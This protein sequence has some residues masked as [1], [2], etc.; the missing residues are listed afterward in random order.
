MSDAPPA[1][2]KQWWKKSDDGMKE[3]RTVTRDLLLTLRKNQVDEAK[4]PDAGLDQVVREQKE[5]KER[6]Y[7]QA[8]KHMD[9]IS[10]AYDCVS[11]VEKALTNTSDSIVQLTHELYKGQANIQINDTR[12]ELREKRPTSENFKDS[13]SD[14]LSSEHKILSSNRD[15]LRALKQDGKDI[16]AKLQDQRVKLSSHTGERRVGMLRDIGSLNEKVTMVPEGDGNNSPKKHPGPDIKD[17]KSLDTEGDGVIKECL[18]LLDRFNKHR[19]KTLDTCERCQAKREEA[20]FRTEETLVK[21]VEQM[22]NRREDLEKQL[23]DVKAAIVKGERELEASYRKLSPADTAKAEKLAADK[24]LLE[25]LQEVRASLTQDVKDKT[26]ALE[27]DNNC[28]RINAA[29]AGMEKLKKDFPMLQR[30]SSAGSLQASNKSNKWRSTG[31]SMN[32]MSTA[33]T[34]SPK[35]AGDSKSLK[36]AGMGLSQ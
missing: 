24:A 18:D 17:N 32:N 10:T 6:V 19:A 5:K 15:E 16:I 36:T 34:V 22:C 13:L 33:S 25:K 35:G 14:A 28:K 29:K 9:V 8:A 12:Q 7:A 4:K 2:F 26:A 31:N 21:R 11:N 3:A 23:R 30:S 20:K 1:S 27:I